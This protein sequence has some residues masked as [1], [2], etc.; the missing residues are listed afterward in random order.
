M[1]PL[2]SL[3]NG[4]WGSIS[5]RRSFGLTVPNTPLATADEVIE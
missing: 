3:S 4:R 1:A 2:R 5:A